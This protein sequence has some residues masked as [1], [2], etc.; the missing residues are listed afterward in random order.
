MRIYIF[1]VVLV[2]PI[3]AAAMPL[4]TYEQSEK[5]E[6]SVMV[7]IGWVIVMNIIIEGW[8]FGYTGGSRWN[9]EVCLSTQG[10]WR[11][12]INL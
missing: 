6:V 8:C 7:K 1:L 11:V 12:R 2:T 9:S 3:P 5:F 10:L 4:P